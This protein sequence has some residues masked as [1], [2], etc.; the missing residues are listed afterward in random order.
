M[1]I[2]LRCALAVILT[3]ALALACDDEGG[4]PLDAATH[5]A[6][7]SD[8]ALSDADAMPEMAPDVLAPDAM[9]VSF[10]LVQAGAS[11]HSIVLNTTA[12]PSEKKAADE[13]QAHVKLCTGVTLPIVTGEPAG[14]GPMVVLGTGAVSQKH[15]VNPTEAQLGTQGYL[16]R[17]IKPHIFIAGTPEAGTLN[18][19]YRFLEDRLGVRWYAPGVTKTPKA[20]DVPI[21]ELNK[22]VKPAFQ[23]RQTSY[24][25]EGRDSA[26]LARMGSNVGSGDKTSPYGEQLKDWG[27]AHTFHSFVSPSTYFATHPEY[28]SEIGGKRRQH[29]TQLC[30]TNPDVLTI[31]TQ[32][33]LAR[34]KADQKTFM[35]GFSQQDTYNYCTCSK[36]KALY[37][38]YGSTSGAQIWFLNELA[39]AT[40]KVYPDKLVS[41]LAYMFTEK[42]PVGLTL[43]PNVAI[44]LCHMYPS[45]DS[46]PIKTCSHNSAYKQN[47]ADWAKLT[48]NLYVWHYITN[49]AHYYTPFPNL[50]AM[51]A[52]MKFY[53]DLGVKGVY[54]Q[55]MGAGGGGGE[56]SLLRP[57]LGMKLLWDPDLDADAVIKDF[58]QGYY[59]AAWS[60]MWA[61]ISLLHDKVTKENIHMYLYSNPA[62]GY[63]PDAVITQAKALLD[64]AA[65]AVK[66]DAT[67]EERVKVARM[68]LTYA[69]FFP[70]SGLSISGGKVKIG[71]NLAPITEVLSFTALMKKHGFKSIGEQTGGPETMT[72]M[73]TLFHLDPAVEKLENSLISVEVVPIMAGRALRI[74]HKKTGKVVTAYNIKRAIFFPLEGGMEGRVGDLFRYYGWVNMGT[75]KKQSSSS[76]TV[77]VSTRNDLTLELTYTVDAV[78]P[79]VYI[80]QKVTNPGASTPFTWV[81]NHLQLDMG[82]LSKTRVAFTDQAGKKVDMD[83]SGVMSTLREGQRLF[84]KEVPAGSWTFSGTKGVKLTQRFKPAQVER[85]WLYAHDATYNMVEVEVW[86]P[87][88]SIAKNKSVELDLELELQ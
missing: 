7:V 35:F 63:L 12:T 32:K 50:R 65:A 46:H 13:L 88:Q 52:D 68:P 11:S 14:G 83:M 33:M 20:T 25:W 39:K 76:L 10:Y 48:K 42:P 64:V 2:P 38:Q 78:K 44:W 81:R 67:L 29:D 15:G 57:Y 74:T 6:A 80:K 4:A 84:Q 85:T 24:R 26:F 58:L 60:H 54:L 53:R 73:A 23:M 16:L 72:Q 36:C 3:A 34:M 86:A 30:L 9:K 27:R 77:E 8:A 17:A 71:T 21:P 61:Y 47:A 31:A 70:R 41:T 62:Q 69:E 45:C 5:D 37:K 55:G 43:H 59:G 51:A 79:V 66:G 49:F 40:A 1:T 18:G 19:V 22:L 82:A 56:L 28:F 87:G 75:V